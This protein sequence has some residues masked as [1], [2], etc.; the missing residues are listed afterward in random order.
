MLQVARLA[1]RLLSDATD[2][3]VAFLETQAHVNGGFKNRAGDPDLYYTVFGLES[4]AAL[5]SPIPT[6]STLDYLSAFEDGASL[7]LVHLACLARCWANLPQASL[8]DD[9]RDRMVRRLTGFHALLSAPSPDGADSPASAYTCFL[10]AGAY[11][12]LGS[13]LPEPSE[14]L[15]TLE[16]LRADDGGFSNRPR[17]AVG[18]TPATAAAVTLRRYLGAAPA[19]SIA[20]WLRSRCHAEGG[21][22]AS[23][24]AP[25]PDLLSTATAIHALVGLRESI[26][27][28]KEPC[29][30]FIDTLWTSK[31]SF[32]GSWADD[33]LDCEYT[34][35]GLLAL[36]HL[37][38]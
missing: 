35:Y 24:A 25:I 12:D 36:G 34:Y 16:S 20:A 11:Q 29:L 1:P 37:S 32:Y 4:L 17:A 3:V 23:P 13:A 5:G 38:L 27:D 21:F 31:G 33:V 9:R 18:S 2:L 6:A 28:I 10:I 15:A 14:V 22:F 26:D 8:D 30:N 7:D 19:P